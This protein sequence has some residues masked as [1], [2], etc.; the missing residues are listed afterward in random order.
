[1]WIVLREG[2][3]VWKHDLDA[4][5]LRH[6]A[7]TGTAGYTGDGG[8]ARKATFNGPKGLAISPKGHLFIVDSENDAIRRIDHR[9]GNVTTVAGSGRAREFGGDGGDP[10]KAR[11]SQP[12]GICI[13]P[14]GT[15][16]VGDTLNHRVRAVGR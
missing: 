12:H 15:F 2:H 11:P 8:P 14:D 7:G 10:L 5:T 9:T 13:A 3:S 6:F 4:G 1:M 16:F